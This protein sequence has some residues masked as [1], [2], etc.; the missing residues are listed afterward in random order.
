MA[1]T[2]YT[3]NKPQRNI[4]AT[5]S[6]YFDAWITWFLD[7]FM[8][9][10]DAVINALNLNDLKDTSASSHSIDLTPGKS[11]VV[12]SGKG[13]VGGMYLVIA[14]SAAPTANSMVVQVD[15][16]SGT[17]LLVDPLSIRGSGT[18]SSWIISLGAEPQPAVG[19]HEV[20]MTTGNGYDSTNNK[21]RGYSVTQ[22]SVGTAI[23]VSTDAGGGT[24]FTIN[25]TGVY[26]IQRN[27]TGSAFSAGIS[28]NSSQLT[29]NIKSITAANRVGLTDIPSSGNEFFGVITK[30]SAGDFI[31]MH[32]SAASATDSGISNWVRMRKLFA[33]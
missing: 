23:S 16:Y 28:V 14:D 7:T 25:E 9:E 12:S 22:L 29:T 3:G 18:K 21:C 33:I 24:R 6:A 2:P 30:F 5:F 17:T 13:F 19:D 20:Y 1:L 8:A 4:R 32:D 31:Y 10:I 11:F 15:S 26:S 27:E